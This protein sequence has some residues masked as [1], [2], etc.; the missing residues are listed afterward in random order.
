MFYT[1]IKE[2]Q[3]ENTS[4]CNARCPMC[5]RENTPDDKS[6]FNETSLS[7]DYFKRIP[8]DIIT[9][10]DSILFNGVLGDPCAANN[11]LEVCE[12]F[13]EKNPNM[14]I[15]I[16]SN[17][18]L[19]SEKFWGKL[20]TVLGKNSKVIFA[21]DGLKDTNHIYRVNVDYDKV[22]KNARAFIE[23]NGQAE[24]QFISFKH[25]EH[26]I[27]EARLTALEMGFSKFFVKPSHRFVMDSLVSGPKYSEGIKLEPPTVEVHPLVFTPKFTFDEWHDSTNQSQISCYAKKSKSAYIEYTGRIFPCCPISSGNMYRRTFDPKDGWD[28]LWDEHGN[29][30]LDLHLHEWETIMSTEFFAEVERRWSVDYNNGRLAACASVCSNSKIKFNNKE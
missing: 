28:E 1:D 30:K 10:L 15:T 12:Y 25:N 19:R 27:E 2:L 11:F 18:G 17:G 23:N 29:D 7:L 9:N 14:L 16:S 24:W 3:I 13:R 5:L 21:I 4:I 22:M 26:Q 6:W 8:D 20:A